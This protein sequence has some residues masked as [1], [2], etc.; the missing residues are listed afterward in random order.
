MDDRPH[1]E[2]RARQ[3]GPKADRKDKAKGINKH[4]GGFN[5]KV[6]S[7]LEPWPT[8][9]ANICLDMQAFAPHSAAKSEKMGRRKAEMD[10]KRL[11]VPL[12]DRT[13]KAVPPPV[14]VAIVGPPG[15]R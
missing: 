7:R 15:V 5:E 14:V 3:A 12:V 1:K 6:C 4:A 10:Q 8:H 11:H 9:Q 2:H 13:P